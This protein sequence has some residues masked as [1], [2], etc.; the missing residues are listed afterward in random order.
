MSWFGISRF[1]PGP[2]Y[3]AVCVLML[4]T[5]P[6]VWWISRPG[7]RGAT[8]RF[9]DVGLL[10]GLPRSLRQRVWFIPPLLRT[11]ALL[12]LIFSLAR[13]QSVGAARTNARGIAIDMVLDV[14]GSMAEEDFVI[15]GRSARRL[16]AVKQVFKDFVLG[17]EG[18]SG[19][20]NDLIGMVVFAMYPD[21]KCPLTL[22]HGNLVDLLR[23]TEIPGF[24][25]GQQRYQHPEANFTAIGDAIVTA[26]DQLRQASEKAVEGTRGAEVARS[27]VMI[28]LSDGANHPAPGLAA[29]SPDPVEAAKLAAS[30]GIKIYTIGAVGNSLSQGGRDLFSRLLRGGAGNSVDEESL[31]AVAAAAGGRYFRATDIESLRTIYDEIDKLERRSTGERVYND[32]TA[33]ARLAALIGLILLGLEL[34]LTQMLFRKIP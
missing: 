5:L 33:A 3:G 21:V 17:E 4:L 34:T 19:R 18:L 23:K 8:L 22:D 2:W 25:D 28:L 9:S 24:V 7:A 16:D 32:H 10:I 14:S 31:K 26:T 29:D 12:M 11:L 15:D 6:W 13:P 1:A 27:L 20:P 30:L